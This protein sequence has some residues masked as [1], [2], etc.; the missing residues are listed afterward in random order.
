M[1][2]PFIPISPAIKFYIYNITYCAFRVCSSS[3]LRATTARIP[4]ALF[5]K[6]FKF[7]TFLPKFSDILSFLNIILTFC[8]KL[9]AC[10]GIFQNRRICI[11]FFILRLC[12]NKTVQTTHQHHPWHKILYH[13]YNLGHNILELYN[14]LVE[15]QLI[16][17][18]TKHSIQYGKLSIRVVSRVAERLKTLDFRK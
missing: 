1:I 2:V 9:H 11:P 13:S 6:I 16:T 5:Q 8:K 10:S 12:V 17:S 14:V 7:F 4:P 3:L 15:I 18:K